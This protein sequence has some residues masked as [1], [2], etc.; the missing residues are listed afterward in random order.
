MRKIYKS[1]QKRGRILHHLPAPAEMQGLPYPP[2]ANSFTTT[3]L[4]GGRPANE[5]D[6]SILI[7]R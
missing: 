3:N 5:Q 6:I 4:M 7:H 2:T 1:Y